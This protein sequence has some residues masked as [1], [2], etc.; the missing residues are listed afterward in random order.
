MSTYFQM[1]G[2]TIEAPDPESY[3]KIEGTPIGKFSQGL[4]VIQ[5]RESHTCSWSVMKLSDYHDL[6]SRWN[7]NKATRGTFVLLPHGGDS[8]TTWR[9][10][11][12]YCDPPTGEYRGNQVHN[13]SVTI[14]LATQLA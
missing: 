7:T 2:S 6:Y 11:T 12:A 1:W 14:R 8:W 5:G 10:I 3:S 9:S 13:V 4:P